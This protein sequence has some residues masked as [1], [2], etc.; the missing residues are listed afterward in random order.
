MYGRKYMGME[1][2]TFLIDGRGVIRSIW[3]K[4][5]VPGHVDA[6]LEALR[7]T[8]VRDDGLYALAALISPPPIR[9]ASAADRKSSISPSRT[10]WTPLVSTP[11]RRSL[12]IW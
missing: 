2:A 12:T 8:R 6:V 1:R 11:V 9:A 10:A 5:K 7:R 3:R 4:V